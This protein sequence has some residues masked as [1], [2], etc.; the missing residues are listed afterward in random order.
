MT[1]EEFSSGAGH[2]AT[3]PLLEKAFGLPLSHPSV[4]PVQ[5]RKKLWQQEKRK[6]LLP[7]RK[8]DTQIYLM[9]CSLLTLTAHLFSCN[10]EILCLRVSFSVSAFFSAS[11]H[12]LTSLPSNYQIQNQKCPQCMYFHSDWL[13]GYVCYC[14]TLLL[15]CTGCSLPCSCILLFHWTFP[16]QNI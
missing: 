11:Y 12:L 16:R 15:C 10:H 6:C 1:K 9:S 13:S 14:I 2:S 5:R 7:L 3:A 4:K 8:S